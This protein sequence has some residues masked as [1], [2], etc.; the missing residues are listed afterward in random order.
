[1]IQKQQTKKK[2]VHPGEKKKG[3]TNGVEHVYTPIMRVYNRKKE[4]KRAHVKKK[5]SAPSVVKKKKSGRRAI[6]FHGALCCCGEG[7]DCGL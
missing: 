7:C 6:L 4:R 1:V 2:R 5:G 3:D